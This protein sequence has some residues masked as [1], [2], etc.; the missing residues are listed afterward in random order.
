MRRATAQM[1]QRTLY[2]KRY[3][4]G[5]KLEGIANCY[6]AAADHI[7]TNVYVIV[8]HKYM[9]MYIDIYIYI[10]TLKKK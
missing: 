2:I 5:W 9:Y 4:H 6:I 1:K 3:F 7:R 8:H 10:Y